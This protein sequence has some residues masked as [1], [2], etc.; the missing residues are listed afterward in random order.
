[1]STNL[2]GVQYFYLGIS[3]KVFVR[4]YSYEFFSHANKGSLIA[5]ITKAGIQFVV[6]KVMVTLTRRLPE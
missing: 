3:T 1:M 6:M 2:G 4:R 5:C